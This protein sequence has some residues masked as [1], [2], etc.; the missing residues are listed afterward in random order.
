MRTE[1]V[2][3]RDEDFRNLVTD[4]GDCLLRMCYLYLGDKMLAEDA[5][6]DT[7]IKAYRN[8]EY[9]RGESSEK[10]WLTRIAINIC[11]NYRRTAWLRLVDRTVTPDSLRE[12]EVLVVYEDSEVVRAVMKLPAMYKEVILLCY[13]QEL[14]AQEIADALKISRDAVFARI[15]RAKQRLKPKLERWYF[16]E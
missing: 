7:F 13:Y 1:K 2:P 3:H 5:V 10:T 9:Y 6:Q 8:W 16:D 4:Y 14:S 15:K 11:K 12:P